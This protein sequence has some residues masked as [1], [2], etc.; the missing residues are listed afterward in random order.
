M[1][2][3][4]KEKVLSNRLLS[5]D[6][7]YALMKIEDDEAL[8][9]AAQE[10]TQYFFQDR[11]D[12]CSIINAR[13]GNCSEDCK[14]CA[15][16]A[17][18]KTDVSLY[19]MIS[20]QEALRHAKHHDKQGIKRF[21]LVTSGKRVTDR[22][23]HQLAEYIRAIK[24]ETN[25]KICASMGLLKTSQLEILYRAGAENYHCNIETAPSNF[26]HLCTTHT[27]EDKMQTIE[28]ARKVGFRICSGGIIGMGESMSQRI[29]MA[30]FLQKNRIYSI[31]LNILSPIPNTPLASV[32]LISERD[33][34]KTVAFFRF[35]NPNA[36]LRFSGGRARLSKETQLRC[37]KIGINSAITGDLLTTTGAK[38]NDDMQMFRDAGFNLTSD[39]D[40][41]ESL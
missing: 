22:E 15:Q 19:S 27:I 4:L 39:S 16:S 29:E 24:S 26:N 11:F 38:V 23:A 28:A 34:M 32:P 5:E 33:I 17:H 12:S 14:W 8:Y 31:P 10:I 41:E 20:A 1:I 6:E 35:I 13:S 3:K 21:A 37:L 40:W 18:Y 25:I 36:Y 9:Q 30:L 7:A 2:D